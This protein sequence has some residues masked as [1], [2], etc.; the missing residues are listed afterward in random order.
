MVFRRT[1]QGDPGGNGGR[2]ASLRIAYQAFRISE[3]C[4]RDEPKLSD[5]NAEIADRL[6]RLTT[7]YPRR[8]FTVHPY[9]QNVKSFEWNLSVS[10]GS[11]GSSSCATS[12]PLNRPRILRP[13]VVDLQYRAPRFDSR[14]YS[15]ETC[16]DTDCGTFRLRRQL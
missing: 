10:T 16:E 12:M 3:A 4:C 14:R 13:A 15:I 7:T 8:G 5:E 1:N 6:I 9:L 2:H 11:I